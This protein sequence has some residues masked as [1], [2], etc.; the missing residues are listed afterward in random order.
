MFDNFHW[1]R[2]LIHQLK[3]VGQLGVNYGT[4]GVGDNP[5]TRDGRALK[6]GFRMG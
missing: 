2:E 6:E 5:F 4:D 1:A 3:M